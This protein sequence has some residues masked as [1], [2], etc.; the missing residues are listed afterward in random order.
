MLIQNESGYG[1]DL[2][3]VILLQWASQIIQTYLPVVLI[4]MVCMTG[5]MNL[6]T[7]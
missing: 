3:E 5:V 7:G 6:K 1:A 4:Y 2:T